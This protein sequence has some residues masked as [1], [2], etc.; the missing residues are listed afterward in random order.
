MKLFNNYPFS[1]EIHFVKPDLNFTSHWRNFIVVRTGTTGRMKRLRTAALHT[2]VGKCRHHSRSVAQ[3]EIGGTQGHKC[4]RWWC[5]I[6]LQPWSD[7]VS[8]LSAGSWTQT[9]NSGTASWEHPTIRRHATRQIVCL[10][11]PCVFTLSGAQPNPELTAPF[12]LGLV[13]SDLRTP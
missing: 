10:W 12:C 9:Q 2:S 4:L 6:Q 3:P 5:K 11:P 1:L 7:A 13:R 8:E